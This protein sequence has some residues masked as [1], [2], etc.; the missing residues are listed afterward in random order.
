[1]NNETKYK[2]GQKFKVINYG[3]LI[4]ENKKAPDQ[5]SNLPTYRED[6]IF[7]WVDIRPEYVGMKGIIEKAVKSQGKDIYATSIASWFSNEQIEIIE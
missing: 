5:L 4:W 7:K 2:P 1:M 6:E 3:H